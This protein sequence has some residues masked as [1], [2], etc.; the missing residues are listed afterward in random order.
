[1]QTAY[2]LP[3]WRLST[4]D[5]SEGNAMRLSPLGVP[6]PKGVYQKNGALHEVKQNKWRWLCPDG[7]AE[8]LKQALA[9]LSKPRNVGE[10]LRA[11]LRNGTEELEPSTLREYTRM[12]EGSPKN[13]GRL[14]HHFGNMKIDALTQ[15]HVAQYLEM[16]KD[17]KAAAMG[18]RERA[19]LSSAYNYGMRKGYAATNPCRGIRRNKERRST[20]E[21]THAQLTDLINRA[22]AHRQT[23]LQAVYL[24]G[25]RLMDVAN[26][27]RSDLTPEGILI[28][29]SKNNV[30]H[31]KAWTPTLRAVVDAALKHADYWAE[32]K[33]R[34]PSQYVFTNRY[35]Q[36]LSYSA[37]HSQQ[38]RMGNP[39]ELRQ[40]RAKAETDSPGTLGHSG[41]MQR[42]YTRVVRTRPVK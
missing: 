38:V 7:D 20:V 3:L 33:A 14:M 10:L 18:N 1:M 42:R 11:Y 21:V 37:I 30:K 32:H 36:R 28:V 22:P 24:L 41:Q 39:F 29:E 35:G 6:L 25:F 15:S 17:E 13:E 27:K 34:A 5:W 8:L 12:V 16:R 23:F 9:G 31:L 2:R 40:V 26:I 19:C 4:D